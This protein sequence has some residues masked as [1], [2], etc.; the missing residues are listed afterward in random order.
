[1]QRA[2]SFAGVRG[3]PRYFSLSTLSLRWHY[4]GQ[5][6]GPPHF[7]VVLSARLNRAPLADD[8]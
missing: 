1:M 2:K 7:A 5:V 3:V 8:M 6:E 4:P